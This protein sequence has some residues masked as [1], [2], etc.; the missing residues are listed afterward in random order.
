[1]KARAAEREEDV[2]L[3]TEMEDATPP[4]VVG[5]AWIGDFG[6]G[7]HPQPLDDIAARAGALLSVGE[8]GLV[9]RLADARILK[10]DHWDSLVLWALAHTEG[11][12]LEPAE[13]SERILRAVFDWATSE[14]IARAALFCAGGLVAADDGAMAAGRTA[15]DYKKAEPPPASFGGM[16]GLGYEMSLGHAA[17]AGGGGGGGARC[18]VMRE[19]LHAEYG[20]PRDERTARILAAALGSFS[21]AP[22]AMEAMEEDD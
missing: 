8:Y 22:E 1:M 14:G 3:V 18:A 4:H 19:R 11:G 6:R 10:G 20:F 9:R 13:E 7:L 15:V 16:R 2:R 12:T 21:A 5:A 17:S